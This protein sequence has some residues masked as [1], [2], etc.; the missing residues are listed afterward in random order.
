MCV[1]MTLEV[2]SVSRMTLE[3]ESVSRMT[4]LIMCHKDVGSGQPAELE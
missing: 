4:S 3:M 1:R 2:E